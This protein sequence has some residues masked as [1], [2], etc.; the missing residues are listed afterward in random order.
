M[1]AAS[2]ME[3]RS[4]VEAGNISILISLLFAI[5]KEISNMDAAKKSFFSVEHLLQG[6]PI[7]LLDLFI[8]I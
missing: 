7:Q 3:G 2:E 5:M 6:L 8:I 1:N 4:L